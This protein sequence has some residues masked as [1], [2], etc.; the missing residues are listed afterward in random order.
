MKKN[1]V[2]NT[3]V[4]ACDRAKESYQ[5]ALYTTNNMP[6]FSAAYDDLS[7]VIVKEA[8]ESAV[9]NDYFDVMIYSKEDVIYRY[10][11]HYT[12]SVK[13]IDDDLYHIFAVKIDGYPNYKV[14]LD[15]VI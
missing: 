7:K 12:V 3:F 5:K 11:D 14:Y 6:G 8:I 13:N 1:E 15:L 9:S 10:P 4:A 2:V